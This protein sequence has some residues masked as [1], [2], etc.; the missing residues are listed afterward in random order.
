MKLIKALSLLAVMIFVTS[1]QAQT[2][3]TPTDLRKL[4]DDYYKWRNENYPVASSDAG[5]HT[6]DNKLTD[7]SLSSLLARRLQVKEI[8]GKVRAMKT[9]N[10]NKNDRI[11][12]FLFR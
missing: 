12:W 2:P 11:D 3:T 6:W 8:L 5:L 7:Y 1:T 9:D 10:W 4:A